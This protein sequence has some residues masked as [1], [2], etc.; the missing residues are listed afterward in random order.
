MSMYKFSHNKNVAF[1]ILLGF[2][3]STKE[4]ALPYFL[5]IKKTWHE[6]KWVIYLVSLAFSL[7]LNLIFDGFI[8]VIVEMLEYS[9]HITMLLH[10]AQLP[11]SSC[12]C[13]LL[14]LSVSLANLLYSATSPPVTMVVLSEKW[15][16][17]LIIC[18]YENKEVGAAS[19][20]LTFLMFASDFK[21]HRSL[22]TGVYLL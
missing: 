17:D 5:S 11:S 2:T 3:N 20:T 19:E 18:N 12:I 21:Q 16:Y 4:L 15:H 10:I 14:I 8:K 7:L 9:E 1:E 6:K 22:K 13:F